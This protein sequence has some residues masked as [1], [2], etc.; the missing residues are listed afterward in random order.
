[1][2]WK[3][4]VKPN[5]TCS[6]IAELSHL[7]YSSTPPQHIWSAVVSAALNRGRL[8]PADNPGDLGPV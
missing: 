6:T 1:M 7:Q 3:T 5:V 2:L 8:R 4:R